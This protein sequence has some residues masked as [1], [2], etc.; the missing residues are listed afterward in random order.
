MARG[1]C[2]RFD[3]D[4]GIGTTGYAERYP[5]RHVDEPFAHFAIW[6][7]EGRTERG[8]VV[9]AR[10]V[11]GTGLDRVAMQQLVA[12]DTLNALLAF[13]EREH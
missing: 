5:E 3:C 13:L 7:R 8:A 6:R 12:E 4:L 1:V 10:R 9:V 11:P 2:L